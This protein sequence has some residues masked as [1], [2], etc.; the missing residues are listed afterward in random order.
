M[1]TTTPTGVRYEREVDGGYSGSLAVTTSQPHDA[2]PPLVLLD[3]DL[4]ASR[5]VLTPEQARAL[6]AA[7]QEAATG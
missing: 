5:L 1:T 2:A 7:L 3:S 6:A 4:L